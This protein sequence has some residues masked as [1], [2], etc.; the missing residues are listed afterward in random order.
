MR[1]ETKFLGCGDLTP[2]LA[3]HRWAYFIIPPKTQQFI[4]VSHTERFRFHGHCD[5]NPRVAA[6]APLIFSYASW[7][8]TQ[9]REKSGCPTAAKKKYGPAQIRT[10]T[11]N[12]C[13]YIVYIEEYTQCASHYTTGPVDGKIHFFAF[14]TRS[15]VCR[16]TL[17]PNR[18]ARAS[19]G[20]PDG[21]LDWH[22]A[23]CAADNEPSSMGMNSGR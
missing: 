22:H 1:R 19:F 3:S 7:V 20:T 5:R 21:D 15:S 8:S 17:K 16:Q 12:I 9:A 11:S 4:W 14:T 6:A 13:F 23:F 18:E 2:P 10:A